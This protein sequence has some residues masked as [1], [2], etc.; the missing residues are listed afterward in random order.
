MRATLTRVCDVALETIPGFVWITHFVNYSNF[1]DSLVI[2]SV[3]ATDAD[4]QRARDTQH[5][6]QLDALIRKELRAMGTPINLTGQQV[7]CDTEAACERDNNGN[8]QQRYQH[9]R[10]H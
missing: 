3:F 2:V 9:S 4:L 8:W 5:D 10:L 6:L 1:P 7:L